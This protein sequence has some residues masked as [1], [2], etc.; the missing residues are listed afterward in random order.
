MAKSR[1]SHICCRS[2]RVSWSYSE[3][4]TVKHIVN[5]KHTD[6]WHQI[7]PNNTHIQIDVTDIS[8]LPG[9]LIHLKSKTLLKQHS[10]IISKHT[11]QAYMNAQNSCLLFSTFFSLYQSIHLQIHKTP[12]PLSFSSDGRS[13]HTV[14]A[15]ELFYYNVHV[16]RQLISNTI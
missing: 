6:T 5:T 3:S 2:Y 12:F 13:L 9:K 15:I 1:M 7:F 16:L 8:N 4:Y 14:G 11:F 10:H